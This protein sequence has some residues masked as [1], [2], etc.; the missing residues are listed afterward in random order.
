MDRLVGF[1]PTTSALQLFKEGVLLHFPSAQLVKGWRR[2]SS[3]LSIDRNTE[4][5]VQH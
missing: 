4:Y 1:E 5:T 3:L 2:H